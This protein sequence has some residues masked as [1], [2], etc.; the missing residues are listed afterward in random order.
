[1]KGFKNRCLSGV[2]DGTDDGMLWN[3]SQEDGN[4]KN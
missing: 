2:V 1:V 3:A 4:D